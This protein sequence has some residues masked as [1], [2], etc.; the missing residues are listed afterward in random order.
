MVRDLENELRRR[1]RALLDAV[2]PGVEFDFLRDVAA[3]V[4]MQ[5]ICILLGMPQE[6]R[7]WLFEAVEPGFD[8]RGSRKS[9]EADATAE[10]LRGRMFAYGTDLIAQK[11]AEPG[12]DMLSIV[13]HATLDDVEPNALTDGELYNVLLAALQRPVRRPP[14]TRSPAGWPRCSNDPSRWRCYAPTRRFLPGAVEEMLRWT[15][16]SPSK[17]RTATRRTTLRDA[18]IEPGEKVV[19]WE[20]SANRDD[21][22]FAHPMDFDITRDPNPHLTFGQRDPPLPRC[23]PRPARDDRDVHRVARRLPRH[24]RHGAGRVDR[25]ATATPESAIFPFW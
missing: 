6:D 18:T 12:D 15:T 16:P 14:A 2:E 11:R 8:F 20:G 19:V 13:V 17:R 1:T 3:E 21:S 22:V 24:R 10:E 23:Q 5:M 9:F 4:P 7:H 25:G